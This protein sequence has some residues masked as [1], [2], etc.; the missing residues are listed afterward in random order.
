[1]TQSTRVPDERM[2]R[3]AGIAAFV[4]TTIEWYDFYIYGTAS[5]LVFGPLFFSNAEPAVA[6]LLSFATFA[7]GFLTR[8]LGGVVFGHLGD[9]I[10][11]KRSLILTLLLMGVTT[12]GVG[13]L[14]THAAIGA[15][16]PVLLIVLRLLQGLAVGGEWGGAVLIATEHTR[17]DRGFLF[18]A[19]AQQGSPAGRILATLSFLAV[20]GLLPDDALLEWAWRLPFLASAA[21]V[22]VGLV[23][24]LSLEESPA[25]KDL[26]ERNEV[27]RVPVVELFRSNSRELTLGV[28][29]ILCVF[30]VVYARDTFA[31]SWATTYLGFEK[32]SFLTIILIA[33]VVQFFVQPFGAVLATRWNP[34]TLVTVLLALE[35][36]ALALMFVLMGT[37]NWTLAMIGAVMA[38]I[39]DVMFYAVMAGMLAQAFPARVRYTGISV[40]YGL[41]GALCGTTPMILQWLLDTS[42]SIVVPVAFGVVTT[43]ISLFCSRALLGRSAAALEDADG[44]ETVTA[45]R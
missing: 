6:T 30:V 8:P 25:M 37:G 13:L 31:L 36:P 42:G 26:Q 45:A 10:G 12:V 11:R 7:V 17:P 3:K 32:D 39:P 34:R 16:A 38:T 28:F 33:S 5:A 29:G 18:G 35:I 23:I 24:R 27:V 2:A 44:P 1:M 4:G 14:P 19:F 21:L 22:V 43:V 41:S 20:T 15:A 9:R 40:T